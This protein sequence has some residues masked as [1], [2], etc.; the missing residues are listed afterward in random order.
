MPQGVNIAWNMGVQI[1]G[2]P[3]IS[4]KDAFTVDAYDMIEVVIPDTV[5][6]KVEIQP[7][8]VAA[9]VQLLMIRSDRY[10]EDLVYKVGADP[11]EFKLDKPLLLIGKGAISMLGEAPDALHFTNTSGDDASIQ[12]LVGR[13]ATP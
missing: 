1:T 8:G 3:G 6:Q 11:T 7:S 13:D 2:G 5:T 10:D 4:L 9:Q 12:I